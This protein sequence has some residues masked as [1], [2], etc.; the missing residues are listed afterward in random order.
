MAVVVTPLIIEGPFPVGGRVDGL[1]EVSALLIFAGTYAVGGIPV[2][3]AMFGLRRMKVN[4][5]QNDV[6]DPI[7][8]SFAFGA[9]TQRMIAT[10]QSQFVRL[11][12]PTGGGAASPT[13]PTDPLVTAGAVAMTSSAANGAADL[14]PGLAKEF[15]NG[16]DVTNMS[17]VAIAQGYL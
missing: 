15:P 3:P 8:K 4:A 16:G 2:T 17:I 14:T 12:Y 10:I 5:L 11:F 7:L 1:Q 13:V 6:L 9:A